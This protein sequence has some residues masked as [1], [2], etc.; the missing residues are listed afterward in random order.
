MKNIIRN[1]LVFSVSLLTF[2]CVGIYE[3][4]TELSDDLKGNVKSISVAE[5]KKKIEKTE[6]FVL[7]DVRQPGDYY[8]ANIPGS[9]SITRGILEFSIADTNFWE[10]QYM[11]VPEK[12]TEIVIYCKSGKRGVFATLALMQLGYKNVRNLEG[13]YDAFN[14][15][16]DPNAKP[17][18]SSGGCGG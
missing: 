16:Q 7:I 12:N 6:D 18:A 1:I 13:G 9:V 8:T 5:L 11:Y 10:E 17:K 14:P 15:N 2:S 3:D 4:G